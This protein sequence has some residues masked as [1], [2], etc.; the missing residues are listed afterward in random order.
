MEQQALAIGYVGINFEFPAGFTQGGM[1][2]DG[3]RGL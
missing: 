1:K 2:P 3:Q